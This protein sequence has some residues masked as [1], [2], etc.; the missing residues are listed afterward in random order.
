MSPQLRKSS[1]LKACF[2]NFSR[3]SLS[4]MILLAPSE[5]SWSWR[6]SEQTSTVYWKADKMQ[7]GQAR[8]RQ[9]YWLIAFLNRSFGQVLKRRVTLRN[10][11]AE[12]YRWALTQP[13]L[14]PVQMFKKQEKPN[15]SKMLR[16]VIFWI[17]LVAQKGWSKNWSWSK[18]ISLTSFVNRGTSQPKI[19]ILKSLVPTKILSST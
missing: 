9:K 5:T 4:E 18:T 3:R 16:G 12:T 6:L 19:M 15:L 13:P 17:T 10:S 2:S 14:Q 11:S 1:G 8:T 7:R